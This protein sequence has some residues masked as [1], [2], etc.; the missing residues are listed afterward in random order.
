M[1]SNRMVK[2]V[3]ALAIKPN[4]QFDT[5]A[6]LVKRENWLP[7]AIWVQGQHKLHETLS[8]IKRNKTKNHM[9]I[10]EL[11]NTVIKI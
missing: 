6:P 2:W 10:L 4:N 1:K 7:P 3:K 5:Q 8:P 9:E 11:K